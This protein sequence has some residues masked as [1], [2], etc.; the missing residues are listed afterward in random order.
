M[1]FYTKTFGLRET[2]ATYK[3]NVIRI[4]SGTLLIVIIL[5]ASLL[6]QYMTWSKLADTL[7]DIVKIAVGGFGGLLLGERNAINQ[8]Q[9]RPPKR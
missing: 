2:D 7:L 4:V 9:R 8:I 1:F 3:L 5:C 6:A